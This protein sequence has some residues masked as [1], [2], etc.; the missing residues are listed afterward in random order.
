MR[1]SVPQR[2]DHVRLVELACANAKEEAERVSTDYERTNKTLEL[3]GSMLKLEHLPRRLESYDISNLGSD[4]IV[5]SMV[6]FVDGN[7]SKKDYKRFKLRD[8][9][10]PNDYGSMQQVIERRFTHF[11]AGDKGFAERPD[12]LLIDGGQVHADT[13]LR[14]LSSMGISI[15]VF[16]MSRMTDT[17][18]VRW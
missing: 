4:D 11:L 1:I 12:A 2:G 14:Q 7:S 15:P 9:D 5:A 6:V 10:G 8:M 3:L 17:G 16:G 13:V 18:P